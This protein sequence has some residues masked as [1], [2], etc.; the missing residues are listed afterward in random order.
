M[1]I[2][3]LVTE[4]NPFHKGHLYHLKASKEISESSHAVAVMS[5]HFLQ[6]GEPALL[7]KWTR[8]KMAIDSGLD[9]V[10]ELPTL[11]AC[12]SAE[13]FAFGAVSL[14]NDLQGVNHLVF[15]SESGCL[16]DLKPISDLLNR[17]TE[18]FNETLRQALDYGMSYPK[19]QAKAINHC[20]QKDQ[21]YLPNNLLGVAYLQAMDRLQSPMT[22]HTIKRV[23]A[24]YLSKEIRGDIASATAI[25]DAL[26]NKKIDAVKNV[27]TQA[28][29][30]T[31]ADCQEDFVFLKTLAPILLYKIRS[32]SEEAIS[33]IHDVTEGLEK[34]IKK[35]GQTAYDYE[36]L[37]ER[38]LSKRY[39][40][41]RIQ[42]IFIKI[43]LNIKNVHI[44]NQKPLYARVLAF[45]EKGQEILNT[46]KKTS[47]IPIITNINK[48]ALDDEIKKQLDFDILA[49]DIYAL[50]RQKEFMHKGGMDHL[51]AP[52][53][54]KQ[55]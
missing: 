48:S 55:T 3:G 28:T 43:L 26:E 53:I 8:A 33:Q 35:A 9:L 24:D 50:L 5:G 11:F 44:I 16:S 25:R 23:K 36:S 10:F 15:G 13:T 18:A 20:L 41:T 46:I 21:E 49:S 27:V 22:P 37:I 6:R 14:L 4:Y 32:M 19:A 42:R 39:T 7:D 54:K 40:R 17:P 52:Y 51:R 47:H 31:L 45:N 34:K 12:S 38:V 2:V 29:Y 30:Q 1:N